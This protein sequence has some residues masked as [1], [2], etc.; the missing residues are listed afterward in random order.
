MGKEAR[1]FPENKLGWHLT[2]LVVAPWQ[3][4]VR[5]D[6]I[7]PSHLIFCCQ[8]IVRKFSFDAATFTA[9]NLH[10]GEN[11]GPQF[12]ILSTREL[13]SRK[14]AAA[15]WKIAYLCPPAT[16][17]PSTLLLHGDTGR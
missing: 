4:V 8:E 16:F 7:A 15:C 13:L 12:E 9:E 10:F 14:F 5:G 1:F 3:G 11:L 6:G 17:Y 2:P